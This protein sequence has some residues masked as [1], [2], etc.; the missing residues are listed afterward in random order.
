MKS[1]SLGV[2]SFSALTLATYSANAQDGTAP[3]P[4][5]PAPAPTEATPAQPASGQPATAPA[6][7]AQGAAATPAEPPDEGHFRWGVSGEGGTFFP[8]PTTI[9]FGLEARF[10]YA[11]NRTVTAFGSAGSVAGIGFGGDS[12][13]NGASVSVSAISYWYIG[14]NVD[15]LLAGPLF[16][17]GGAALGRGGWG[18]VSQSASSTGGS[19]EVIAAGGFMPSANGRLGL[20]FGKTNEQTGKRSGFMLALDLRVLIAP[21]SAKTTQS[22]GN[23]GASQSVTVDTTAI[24]F[25]PMLMLGYDLR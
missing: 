11:F 15:A 14:A 4:T 10:G 18:V 1:L 12:G 21:N 8:G 20:H 2:L 6:T 23:G 5:T 3:P 22:A 13:P 19:Q 9:A 24:G 17:G 16:V 7:P 25:S